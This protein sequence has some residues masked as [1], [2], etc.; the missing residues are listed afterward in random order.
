MIDVFNEL[1]NINNDIFGIIK[2]IVAISGFLA[3]LLKLK[4]AFSDS[5][6]RQNLKI[7]FEI[8]EMAQKTHSTKTD[9]LKEKLEAEID[10]LYDEKKLYIRWNFWICHWA[11]YC[12]WVCS[13]DSRFISE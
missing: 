3:L 1:L 5:Q 13:L 9:Q 12:H 6:R 8:L 10:Y 11:N 2:T 4:E 7:D